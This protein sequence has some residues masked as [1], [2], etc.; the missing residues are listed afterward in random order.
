MPEFDPAAS[1]SKSRPQHLARL[2]D[3]R[4][5]QARLWRA[6]ELAAI[7]R[8]QLS[9]P[10]V[11]DLGALDP[12]AAARLKL[13]SEAQGLLLKSF[14][15][16]FQHP[17]PLLELLRLTKDFA[18]SNMDNA[19]SCLPSEIAAVL[20]Y[21]AITSALVRLHVRISKL[22]DADLQRGLAWAKGQDWVDERTRELLDA[23][24]KKLAGGP[25]ESKGAP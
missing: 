20:Y 1:V 21:L 6:D 8:H 3:A 18:K 4:V 5:E 22:P 19:E 25:A 9:A 7:F 10:V 15:E 13:L 17:A 23:G 11:L 12:A 16:L 24:L 2:L 14:S